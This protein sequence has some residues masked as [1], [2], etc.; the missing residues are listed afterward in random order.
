E[1]AVSHLS[2]A[3]RMDPYR[4]SLGVLAGFPK[5]TPVVVYS[6]AGYRGARTAR[7]LA[8]Q[9]YQRVQNLGS[10]LFQ[11]VNEGRPMFRGGEPTEVVHPYDGGWGWGWLLEG[12]YRAAVPAVERH[13]V[14]P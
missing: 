13:S 8:D 2:G 1:F 6:S 4:P 5:D 3:R 7:W 12:E 11:W 10:S 14:A 9:G